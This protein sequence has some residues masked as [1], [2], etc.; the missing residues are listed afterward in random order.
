MSSVNEYDENNC[1]TQG[2]NVDYHKTVIAKKKKKSTKHVF[3]PTV[4]YEGKKMIIRG[5]AEL[6]KSNGEIYH[7]LEKQ[8]IAK[9]NKEFKSTTD[10][11]VRIGA[12]ATLTNF[13]TVK[14]TKHKKPASNST[15]T[16]SQHS[17]SPITPK[18]FSK[19]TTVSE[20]TD[21]DDHYES[22]DEMDD[23]SWVVRECDLP[24]IPDWPRTM[25][26]LSSLEDK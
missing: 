14:V 22:T 7:T 15:V 5:K 12:Q 1:V 3:V 20:N 19:H 10:N 25:L 24:M 23:L 26:Y 17:T 8:A 9:R 2:N 18:S 11:E 13:C 21:Y 16:T 6:K 4:W